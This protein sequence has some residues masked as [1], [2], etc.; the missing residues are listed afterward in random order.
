MVGRTKVRSSQTV[1]SFPAHKSLKEHLNRLLTVINCSQDFSSAMF[2]NIFIRNPSCRRR[3]RRRRRCYCRRRHCRRRRRFR[4]C[5][6]TGEIKFLRFY[7]FREIQANLFVLSLR[8]M[9]LLKDTKR[10]FSAAAR[11]SSWTQI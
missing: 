7:N 8:S 6:S 2:Y 4:R 11:V 9:T 3:C 5:L 1:E 10:S